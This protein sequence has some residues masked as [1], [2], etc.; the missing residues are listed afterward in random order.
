MQRLLQERFKGSSGLDIDSWARHLAKTFSMFWNDRLCPSAI[1]KCSESHLC[2]EWPC[3]S[4]IKVYID[5]ESW[6]F[7]S[8]SWLSSRPVLG[9]A[10]HPES[11]SEKSLKLLK[12]VLKQVHLALM[13]KTSREF[14]RLTENMQTTVSVQHVESSKYCCWWCRCE[15][16]GLP[17]T[18]IIR[19]KD[20]AFHLHK[21]SL[22]PKP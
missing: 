9:V 10:S 18:V 16:T 8:I 13:K 20:R 21:V 1:E 7:W 19:V 6:F 22:N 14:S 15:A 17:T 2:Y 12:T 5:S 4:R 11:S 3:N